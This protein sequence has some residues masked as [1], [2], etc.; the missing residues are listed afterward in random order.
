MPDFDRS[1][2]ADWARARRYQE[3]PAGAGVLKRRFGLALSPRYLTA[4]GCGVTEQEG[5]S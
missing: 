2:A 4:D 3:L 5:R 1:I